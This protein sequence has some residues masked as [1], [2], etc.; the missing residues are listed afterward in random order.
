MKRSSSHTNRIDSMAE[1]HSACSRIIDTM[2]SGIYAADN[3]G[4]ISFAN[5]ALASIFKYQNTNDIIGVNFARNLYA[6]PHDRIAFLKILRQRGM[7]CDYTIRMLRKDGSQFTVSARSNLMS[8]DKGNIVG[9]EGV[10]NEI[11][12]KCPVNNDRPSAESMV[13]EDQTP[14]FEEAVRDPLTHAYNYPYFCNQLDLEIKRINQHF[15]PLCL[16]MI[17]IDGFHLYNRQ[18]GLSRGDELLVKLTELLN[19]HLRAADI[20][21][22]QSQDQF[23]V[24]LPNTKTEEAL[25]VAKTIKNLV[26]HHAFYKPITCSIGLSRYIPGMTQQ[27]LFLKANLGLCMAQEA[28]QNE[29]CLYG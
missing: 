8:D 16:M 24:I 13:T 4:N 1:R 17:D 28:G 23:L 7:V 20:L 26:E 3:N 29:A 21:C 12:D 27:E 11:Q 14:R 18:H 10:L 15:T 25:S 19:Q 9:V 6:N 5:Q 2:K 22:R